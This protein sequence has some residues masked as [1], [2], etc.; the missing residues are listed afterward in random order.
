L[1][2]ACKGKPDRSI[3]LNEV[4]VYS[5]INDLATAFGKHVVQ[6]ALE[7]TINDDEEEND[8]TDF[9]EKEDVIND[10]KKNV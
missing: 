3:T 1:I 2:L 7:N 10:L 9:E 5:I 4:W 6:K 8:E